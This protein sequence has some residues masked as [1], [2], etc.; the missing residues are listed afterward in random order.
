MLGTRGQER[1]AVTL[2]RLY[3]ALVTFDIQ[4]VKMTIGNLNMFVFI[5]HIEHIDLH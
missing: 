3:W 4:I 2:R 5:P 1:T